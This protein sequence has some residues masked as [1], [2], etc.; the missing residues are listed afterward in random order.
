MVQNNNNKKQLNNFSLI[1]KNI[2]ISTNPKI[3]NKEKIINVDL[4]LKVFEKYLNSK[5]NVMN[6]EKLFPNDK[7]KKSSKKSF[8]LLFKKISN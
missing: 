7:K 4:P 5:K 3:I 6:V 2:N 1:K 8:E